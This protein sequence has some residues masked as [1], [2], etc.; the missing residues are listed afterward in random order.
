MFCLRLH[1][2]VVALQRAPCGA[3]EALR[4]ELPGLRLAHP[5]M[6]ASG[7]LGSS[8]EGFRRLAAA[9]VS[10]IVTK[11]FT[12]EPR[13]GYPTP[14]AVP[15]EYGM[16][17]AVGL[18]NPGLEG[19]PGLVKA[20]KG[21]GLPVVASIAASSPGEAERLTAAA[22]EAGADAVELNLSCP[23]ARGRGLVLL[24][25]RRAAASVVSAAASVSDVPVYAK[26]GLVDNLP[27]AASR[28][29]EAG[30][31]G[32]VLLN[33]LPAMMIDVYAAAPVLG[34]R[35]GG[36]SGPAMHPVAVRAVYEVYA[37]T[38][39][40]IIGVGGVEDWASAAELILA[41]ASAV[42]IGTGIVRRGEQVVCET[43][44]GLL[45]WLRL[46]GYASIREA[47]GAAQRG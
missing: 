25:D 4:V 47:V 14:I 6:N 44:R 29:L 10:A 17:N 19:L 21:L 30:A 1:L 46:L 16:L 41:G 38:G 2:G 7:V 31:A 20:A 32:L 11:S 18:S 22:V 35:V 13:R 34:N 45:E 3:A 24:W 27:A 9:G 33:T 5:V 36:L 39:A 40:P 23:H 26:L 37:E 12:V 42:Q 43:A 15:L 28:L 8:P